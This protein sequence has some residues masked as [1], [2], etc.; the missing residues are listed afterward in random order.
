MNLLARVGLYCALF[1][2][3]P[4]CSGK[5]TY[6][7]V[8]QPTS[9]SQVGMVTAQACKGDS[10]SGGG[11]AGSCGINLYTTC[12]PAWTL[13]D[14]AGKPP[15]VG[16]DRIHDPGTEPVPCWKWASTATRA[17]V[18]FNVMMV[19]P[20]EKV[21]T[22]RLAW[23]PWS[24]HQHG[25]S[26]SSNQP[27]HCFK[28]LFEATAPWSTS[29]GTPGNLLSDELDQPPLAKGIATEDLRKVIQKWVDT[30]AAFGFFFT[31]SA[32]AE[33]LPGKENVH[34]S[35]ILKSLQ[36]E[37]TYQRKDQTFP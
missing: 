8:F 29:S 36:L 21:V 15:E 18:N 25:G 9:T 32:Y 26:H 4:A 14:L 33:S 16:S 6:Q 30:G 20:I 28:R 23:D 7:H 24:A 3:L 17:Y 22:A 34:C 37:I 12:P 5:T 1:A 35:T 2:L 31:P 27:P 11:F 10:G 19:P 13:E